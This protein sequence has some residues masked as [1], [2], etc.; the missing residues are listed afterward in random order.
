[1]AAG[2]RYRASATGPGKADFTDVE[3]SQGSPNGAAFFYKPGAKV[4]PV[5]PRPFEWFEI[6]PDGSVFLCCPAW[7]KRPVGN[8]LRQS[9]EEIWNSP[10]AVELRKTILNGSFH[11]CSARRCPHLCRGTGLVQPLQELAE[12]PSRTALTAGESRLSYPPQKLN[13][14]FDHGCNLGCPSCRDGVQSPSRVQREQALRIAALV[15]SQLLP[16]AVEV[17]LSGFGDP[18]AAAG[19]RALL[20]GLSPQRYPHLQKLFL[21]SNGQ[22][23]SPRTWDSLPGLHRLLAGVEISVD[24]ATAATY[25]VNRPGGSFDRLLENLAF[26]AGLKVPLKLSMVVQSNNFREIPGLIALGPSLGASCYFSQL[27]NWGTFSKGEF[28]RRAVH[29]PEHPQHPELLQTLAECRGLPGVDL[30]NLGEQL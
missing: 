11:S 1:M 4:K 19:Y 7:L 8:L 13:L 18:F 9:V 15:E 17:T 27:V 28:E 14:C 22:L 12:G 23:F 26:I 25:A 5:C 3:C 24:A 2:C 30:G 20:A 29:L 10:V 6:H 21:N 16:S